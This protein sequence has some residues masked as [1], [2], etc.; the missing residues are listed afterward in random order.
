MGLVLASASPR[1]K[2]LLTQLFFSHPNVTFSVLAADI[3]E[4][5]F[6]DE[7]AAE[8]VTRL[9]F[10]KAKAGFLLAKQQQ[11]RHTEIPSTPLTVLGSDT[12]VVLDNNI[13]GKPLDIHDAKRMLQ[14]LSAQEHY[15]MTA[16]AITDGLRTLD[17]L[18]KTKV[19]FCS[20]S[21]SDI[22]DY[23]ATMEPMDKAGA[24]G[25]QGMGGN[26]VTR[27]EGSY[28]AVVGLPL[29]ETRDLL[30]EMQILT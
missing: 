4:T 23:I 13:L 17:R 20:L 25:I 21:T 16:V 10:E 30:K 12:I 5:P 2:E 7:G 28:S 11:E 14:A 1:R 8:L 29:V 26:F 22:E 9:A 15:V 6:S 24:Y 27:I 18:V 19:C 3:D